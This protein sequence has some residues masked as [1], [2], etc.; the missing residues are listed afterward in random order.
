[1][2]YSIE[3]KTPPCCQQATNG[4]TFLFHHQLPESNPFVL[5]LDQMQ[6][7]S[8][9]A[10]FHS[11]Q[12]NQSSRR[13]KRV[14][15]QGKNAVDAQSQPPANT[16]TS[17]W[18]VRD[19]VWGQVLS[20]A[21]E[22]EEDAIRWHKQHVEQLS[23][24]NASEEESKT[25]RTVRLAD[26]TGVLQFCIP[27]VPTAL[28][29]ETSRKHREWYERQI[30]RGA[31][32]KYTPFPPAAQSD[33]E[34]RQ[35]D[36]A[37]ATTIEGNGVDDQTWRAGVPT[38]TRAQFEQAQ[39]ATV[40]SQTAYGAFQP[41]NGLISG[42]LL[43]KLSEQ[44]RKAQPE[45]DPPFAPLESTATTIP[46]AGD[47]VEKAPPAERQQQVVESKSKS[48]NS[49][50]V[51]HR[52]TRTMLKLGTNASLG[53]EEILQ[54]LPDGF[55]IVEYPIVEIYTVDGFKNAVS[56]GV[57]QPLALKKVASAEAAETDTSDS[58]DESSSTESS[59]SDDSS[60]T[61]SS[62]EAEGGALTAGKRAA[63]PL[64]DAHHN[65]KRPKISVGLTHYASD[66]D[67]DMG[68]GSGEEVDKNGARQSGEMTNR[69]MSHSNRPPRDA[70]AAN[71]TS[72]SERQMAE[73]KAVSGNTPTPKLAGGLM[74]PY[75]IDSDEEAED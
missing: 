66:S 25:T 34:Q 36:R 75:A 64:H 65:V 29:N 58:S 10:S 9:G 30:A 67:E 16:P 15:K 20:A 69:V 56:T 22:T 37:L 50:K 40:A 1:M 14:H 47:R 4:W 31:V 70:T 41:Q 53:I 11:S 52:I 45:P 24:V 27:L 68:T 46:L 73:K 6:K 48:T 19:H 23:V 44:I 60:T 35:A 43:N 17:T 72:T 28:R 55:A 39:A 59:D 13:I 42:S 61:C 5:L 3:L 54:R 12:S 51:A 2:S 38:G 7:M 32:E 71:V 57:I 49:P 21:F 63:A 62:S 74:L 33:A 8:A 26:L 18:V